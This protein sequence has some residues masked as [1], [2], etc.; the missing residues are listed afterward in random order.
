MATLIQV[1]WF[2]A[3]KNMVVFVESAVLRDPLLTNNPAFAQV[4]H[5]YLRMV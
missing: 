1:K 3:A 2:I 4:S 5:R